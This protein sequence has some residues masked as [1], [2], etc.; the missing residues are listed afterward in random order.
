MNSPRITSLPFTGAEDIGQ[1]VIAEHEN[2][3]FP[4]RRAYWTF[5]VP[6]EKI[7]GHHAHHKLQQ[8]IIA[9]HGRLEIV[10]ETPDRARH[11]F[12]LNHPTQALF[13]PQMCWREIRF[14]TDAVLLCPASREYDEADYIRSYYDFARLV[15]K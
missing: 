3:P 9:L 2:L 1:L 14:G 8:L 12:V 15:E 5:G 4:V 7:R 13:I 6:I 11:T 10:V